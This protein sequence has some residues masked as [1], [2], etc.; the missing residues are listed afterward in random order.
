[1]VCALTCCADADDQDVPGDGTLL[2]A[3]ASSPWVDDL[4]TPV[5]DGGG[6]QD[7]DDD[8]PWID[9]PIAPA[10]PAAPRGAGYD[11]ESGTEGWTASGAP[12]RGVVRATT[13][14]ASGSAALA[15]EIDGA[16]TALVS[17]ANP[18]ARPGATVSF[19]I[20]VPS[21]AKLAWVQP[22]VQQDASQN[23]AWTGNY[24]VLSNLRQNAWNQLT[25]QVPAGAKLGALGVQ[26]QT[27]GS[28]RGRIYVDDVRF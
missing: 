22:F 9:P 16:G 15:V 14:H 27:E 4:P 7:D 2:A 26:L 6:T 23:W 24:Q 18:P 17:V 1:L 5:R 20:F 13:Q 10:K 25:V 28:F 8:G 11:F 3:Q 19:R 12:I 21:G